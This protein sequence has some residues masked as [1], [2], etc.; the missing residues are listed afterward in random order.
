M[1]MIKISM[2][3]TWLYNISYQKC[4]QIFTITSCYRG[5]LTLVCHNTNFATVATQ[6]SDSRWLLGGVQTQTSVSVCLLCCAQNAIYQCFLYLCDIGT[7]PHE[8]VLK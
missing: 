3:Q 2:S 6:S 5:Q 8:A 4:Y 1:V 7:G